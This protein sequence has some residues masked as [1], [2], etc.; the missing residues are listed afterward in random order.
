MRVQT[1]RVVL[2][3][4]YTGDFCRAIKSCDVV[5]RQK[6]RDKYL[7]HGQPIFSAGDSRQVNMAG[8]SDDDE[9]M[10]AIAF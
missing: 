10:L 5:A 7:V 9:T 1:I 8:D 2:S 4:P 3:R 6:S